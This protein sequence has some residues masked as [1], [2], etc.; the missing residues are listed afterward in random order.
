MELFVIND[1][2]NEVSLKIEHAKLGKESKLK[3]AS[4]EL[5]KESLLSKRRKLLAKQAKIEDL[6]AINREAR[7]DAIKA[8]QIRYGIE[9]KNKN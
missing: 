5:R 9:T 1:K 7:K 3:I 6:K 8:H 4:L 2:I